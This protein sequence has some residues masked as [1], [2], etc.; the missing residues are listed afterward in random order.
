MNHQSDTKNKT[1]N[2]PTT[3]GVP[4][5]GKTKKLS[6]AAR[7]KL[8]KMR[9]EAGSSR[10]P[11]FSS[12]TLDQ[13]ASGKQISAS[14]TKAVSKAGTQK[15]HWSESSTRK[16][17]KTGTETNTRTFSEVTTGF[18]MAIIHEDLGITLSEEE[19]GKIQTWIL[20][21]IDNISIGA[22][23]PKFIECLHREGALHITCAD[24]VSVDW[25]RSELSGATPWEG[26]KL[27]FVEERDLSKTIRAHAWIPESQEEPETVLRRIEIQ[28]VGVATS[29]WQVIERKAN[30]RG[31]TLIVLM[32]QTSWDK[33]GD[34]CSHRPYVNLTRAT[35]KLLSNMKVGGKK[36]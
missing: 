20:D 24:Q 32:N 25:L 9:K 18:R 21:R 12:P 10:Q 34:C 15:R 13:S 28:N 22:V 36:R 33:M 3:S 19:T 1:L 8:K 23:S 6:G 14:P 2:Q 27:R 29:N 26:G 17:F 31:Q 5:T 35:F 7:R 11:G 4:G 30:G 16:K